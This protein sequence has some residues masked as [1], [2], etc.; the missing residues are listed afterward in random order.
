M[1]D[2][3]DMNEAD[4]SLVDGGH[5]GVAAGEM[6]EA[7][8]GA[9]RDAG[10]GQVV[11]GEIPDAHDLNHMLWTARCTL[12]SH[13]LLGTFEDRESAE[14]AKQQHLLTVHGFQQ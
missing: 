2:L 8:D 13:G 3:G 11:V 10:L 4:A 9:S 12:P 5:P 1:S 7:A 14:A 6:G